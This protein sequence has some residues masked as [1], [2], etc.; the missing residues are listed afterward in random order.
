MLI[1]AQM[2]LQG[3]LNSGNSTEARSEIV[4]SRVSIR[5]GRDKPYINIVNDKDFKKRKSRSNSAVN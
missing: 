1:A 5:S 4:Q 2:S 3:R